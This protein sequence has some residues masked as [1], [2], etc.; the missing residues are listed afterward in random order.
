MPTGFPAA[1]KDRP[2]VG[3]G[4]PRPSPAESV[5]L[6]PERVGAVP[7]S[8][9]SAESSTLH[10][11]N[12]SDSDPDS[13]P[14]RL[15]VVRARTGRPRRQILPPG[16]RAPC[17]ADE[18]FGSARQSAAR[19]RPARS[20][21]M[22]RGRGMAA[23]ACSP[24]PAGA[25]PG[26]FF[27]SPPCPAPWRSARPATASAASGSRGQGRQPAGAFAMPVRETAGAFAMPVRE[28]AG[29]CAAIAPRPGN[30]VLPSICRPVAN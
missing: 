15:R 14:V 24:K 27:N 21:A 5:T 25:C 11:E 2:Q 16:A 20:K 28:T 18:G 3:T 13:V 8:P 7:A 1:F 10:G 30:A 12:L 9:K 19:P 17:Q 23:A 22:H 4:R 6:S 29:E 26:Q